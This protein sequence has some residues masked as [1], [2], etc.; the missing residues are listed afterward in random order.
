MGYNEI[1][2]HGIFAKSSHGIT[3]VFQD[4]DN[5]HT[6][7]TGQYNGGGGNGGNPNPNPKPE[8]RTRTL[9]LTRTRTLNPNPKPYTIYPYLIYT[10]LTT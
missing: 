7:D 1:A 10:R 4:T 3:Y 9:A 2:L 6:P 5:G 8:T